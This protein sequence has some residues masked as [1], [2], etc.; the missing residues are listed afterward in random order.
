MKKINDKKSINEIR[1]SLNEYVLEYIIYID[2]GYDSYKAL[3]FLSQRNDG[4]LLSEE[5]NRALNRMS[6]GVSFRNAVMSVSD[7]FYDADLDSFLR[8]ITRGYIR[9]EEST[10][11]NLRILIEKILHDEVSI[12]KE[13]ADRASTKLTFPITL[14]FLAIIVISIY[15]AIRQFKL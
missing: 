2:S 13:K 3:M 5:L 9:G 4:K 11:G 10:A 8:I 14:I 15:P 12:K 7:R 1:S 6:N